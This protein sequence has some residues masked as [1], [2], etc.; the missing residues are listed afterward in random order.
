[1]GA[2]KPIVKKI[3]ESL[4]PFLVRY[5]EQADM[6]QY[7]YSKPTIEFMVAQCTAMCQPDE[8]STEYKRC[9]FL[10]TPSIYF[11]LKDKKVKAAAKVFDVR[12]LSIS[13][14]CRSILLSRRTRTLYTMTSTRLMSCRRT[15]TATLT[16]W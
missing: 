16:W 6:N 14:G 13:N 11:S 2:D 7:W 12:L 8:G 1:M 9:A 15:S 5:K 3:M 10:S 4:N